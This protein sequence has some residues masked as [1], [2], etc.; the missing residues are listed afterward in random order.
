[1]LTVGNSGVSASR[2]AISSGGPPSSDW[3]CE[4]GARRFDSLGAYLRD[5]SRWALL[6][7]DDEARLGE[8]IQR[9]FR[10]QETLA[11][12]EALSPALRSELEKVARDGKTSA[13]RFVEANL[14]LVVHVASSIATV[15]LR[16]PI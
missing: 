3:D 11:A 6:D 2:T 8:A 4:D 12:N 10:A 1:M 5:I 13:Q 7:R 14:R 9:G 16:W 15:G